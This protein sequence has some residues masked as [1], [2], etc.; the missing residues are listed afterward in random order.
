MV[1]K[2]FEAGLCHPLARVVTRDRAP[3]FPHHSVAYM[4]FYF[5]H[6]GQFTNAQDQGAGTNMQPQHNGLDSITLGQLKSLVGTVPKP[7]VRRRDLALEQVLTR[8]VAMVL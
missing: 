8:D 7:K 5:Q 3:H 2:I 6:P 1:S 4:S